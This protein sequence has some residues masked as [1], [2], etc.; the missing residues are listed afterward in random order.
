MLNAH[1]DGDR[2]VLTGT[3]LPGAAGL[4][5]LHRWT[6][7]V[8]SGRVTEDP[9]DGTPSEYPRLADDRIGLPHRFGYTVS[10]SLDPEPER[11]TIHKY[12]LAR[13][14]ERTSHGLPLGHTCGEPVFVPCDGATSEDDGFLLTFAH[15][16]TEDTSYLLILDAG[17]VAAA[18]IAEV[19]LPVRV[20]AGF[21]GTWLPAE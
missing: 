12:D 8:G 4:P 11:S 5:V 15:D 14:A 6:I 17:D 1:D 16:R 18:P 2:I 10:F 7:D 13:D 9:L 20:P 21:H 3:R 19:H